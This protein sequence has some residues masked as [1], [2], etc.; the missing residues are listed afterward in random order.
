MFSGLSGLPVQLED[1]D[2]HLSHRA[3][4]LRGNLFRLG[5]NVSTTR[6]ILRF[7]GSSN[8]GAPGTPVIQTF[9]QLITQGNIVLGTMT[10]TISAML[11]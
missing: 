3:V 9:G 7:D 11:F 8:S 2:Q 1:V 5:L 4:E 10:T 6:A